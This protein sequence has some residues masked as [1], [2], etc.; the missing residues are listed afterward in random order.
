MPLDDV[1]LFDSGEAGTWT[2]D[3]TVGDDFRG[4]VHTTT[5]LSTPASITFTL[6]G[7]VPRRRRP[8]GHER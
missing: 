1:A 6:G 5:D 3:A 2:P 4:T 8:D 7:R